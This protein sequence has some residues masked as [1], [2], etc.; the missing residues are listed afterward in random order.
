MIGRIAASH[1]TGSRF[2]TAPQSDPPEGSLGTIA[3]LLPKS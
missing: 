3:F 1:Q 2:L